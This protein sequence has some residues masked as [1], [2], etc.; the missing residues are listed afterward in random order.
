MRRVCSKVARSEWKIALTLLAVVLCGQAHG[1]AIPLNTFLQ[2]SFT[3]VDVQAAGCDPADPA[4]AFCVPSSGTPS[5]FLDAPPWTFSTA[6]PATLQV[7]D[8]FEAGDRFEV[9]DLGG[10]LGL[11]SAPGVADCG[12]D[13]A[14]CLTNA[15]IS[16][17]SFLLGA[18]VH[19]LTIVPRL[20]NAGG[21]TG[22]LIVLAQVPEPAT[23]SLA[24]LVACAAAGFARRKSAG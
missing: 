21:G 9:F 24:L 7:T 19:S 20:V 13:P 12:D 4:G 6:T 15:A 11:T 8:V 1:G 14:V 18:G 2:F 3:D 23:A 22:Y 16:S 17:G 5:A 10:S